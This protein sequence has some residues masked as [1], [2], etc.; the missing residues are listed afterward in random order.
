M[1]KFYSEDFEKGI[2][3]YFLLKLFV[4]YSNG[5]K[6]EKALKRGEQLGSFLWRTGL[7][8]KVILKNLEIAFPEK[9]REWRNNIG[10]ECYKHIGRILF[11][12]G[13]LPSYLCTGEIK[14]LVVFEKGEELL[15]KYRDKGAVLITGH[16]GNWEISGAAL[17]SRGYK[18]YALAYKQKNKKVN[19]FLHKIRTQCC[20]NMIYHRDSVKPLVH[21]LKRGEYVVFLADQNTA[22]DRGVF[23]DFFGVK[24]IAVNFPAKLAVKFEKPVLFF[25]TRFDKTTL[26][27]KIIVEEIKWDKGKS[28]EESIYNLVQEYTRKIENAIKQCPSQYLWGHKRWKTRPPGEESLY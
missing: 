5:L 6:R 14:E 13:R 22:E 18:L 11:E 26:K 20:V 15:E 25:Y 8:K 19:D 27:Y 16:L 3:V 17:G 7:R 28:E 24:A 21:A 9:N 4:N 1:L 2:A 10:L 23:V 12:F